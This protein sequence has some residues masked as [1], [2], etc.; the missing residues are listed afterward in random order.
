MSYITYQG[1]RV[2]F[3]GN[4]NLKLPSI[5]TGLVGYWN[6]D[7]ASGAVAIDST[8]ICNGIGG[9]SHEL[10]SDTNGVVNS[11]MSFPA[12]G[13]VIT[14]ENSVSPFAACEEIVGVFRVIGAPKAVQV[15]KTVVFSALHQHL[16]TIAD[17]IITGKAL[18][19]PKCKTVGCGNFQR[20]A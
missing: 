10:I 12:T 17:F 6:L 9:E 14:L 4:H 19:V 13:N 20:I 7:D 16:H 1:K 3:G 11:C 15:A 18:V 5:N 8:G 2:S